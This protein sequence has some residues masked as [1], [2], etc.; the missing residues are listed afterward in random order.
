MK[1]SVEFRLKF[2]VLAVVINLITA[3]AGNPS[4]TIQK[5][6]LRIEYTEWWGDYTLLVA[7]EL[8]LFEKYGVSVEPVLYETYSDSY[9]DLAAGIL[10]GG[11]FVLGD[12]IGIN[13][14]S[15]L[16]IVAVY[17]DGGVDYLLGATSIQKTSD[18][19]GKRIGVDIS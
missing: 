4:T 7:Q 3:C 10:D 17:D 8:G 16:K 15:P 19:K 1:S 9:S 18:L 11:L 2:L 6:P 12:A 13:D 14:R 5:E